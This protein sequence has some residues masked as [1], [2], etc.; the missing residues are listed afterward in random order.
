MHSRFSS[1]GEFSPSELITQCS[2]AGLSVVSL[3]DHNSVKGV[4]EAVRTGSELGLKVLPGLELDCDCKGTPI[5]LLGYCFSGLEE[6]VGKIE[7]DF[8]RQEQE[9]G[10]V[11]MRKIKEL[12][13]AFDE[14]KVKA[15][16]AGSLVGVIT[17]EMIAETF[18]A[19]P[20]NRSNPLARPYLPGGLR[21]DSPF[22]NFYWD[23][24]GPGKPAYCPMNLISFEEANELIRGAGGFSVLAHP[25][26]TVKRD[27]GLIGYMAAC[28]V[29]GIETHCSYHSPE[30]AGFYAGIAARYGLMPSIGSDYHGKTKPNVALGAVPG[31]PDQNT[32]LNR[33][34]KY[35]SAAPCAFAP[36][37]TTPKVKTV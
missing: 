6:A 18:L 32:L 23:Y 34:E 15:L 1:D 19:D 24:F 10:V 28:G 13:M 31:D 33:L 5:H 4:A 29:K 8:T 27:A 9:I 26:I 35:L 22:V 14:E 2:A 36:S 30:D 7:E 11:R 16:A 3:T 20:R 37:V 17:V 25:A 21:S 12:G